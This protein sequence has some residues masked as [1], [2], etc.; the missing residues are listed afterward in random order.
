MA[1]TRAR[2]VVLLRIALIAA[3]MGCLPE[4]AQAQP[5]DPDAGR[6]SPLEA[7]LLRQIPA[8]EPVEVDAIGSPAEQE[9]GLQIAGFLRAHGYVVSTLRI[10][11]IA[12][13]PDGPVTLIHV[14][15]GVR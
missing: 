7:Q 12:P 6:T 9:M 14:A 3:A 10:G 13:S 1:G 4:A 8:D 15:P 11:A 5:A 2:W